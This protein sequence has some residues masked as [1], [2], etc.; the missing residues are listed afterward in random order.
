[1]PGHVVVAVGREA[2]GDR[3]PEPRWRE[4]DHVVAPERGGERFPDGGGLG[5]AVDEDDGHATSSSSRVRSGPY[6]GAGGITAASS[7]TLSNTPGRDSTSAGSARHPKISLYQRNASSS[8]A[9]AAARAAP[10]A[11]SG[12]ATNGTPSIAAR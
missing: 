12:G 3:G 8:V 2:V 4:G 9:T 6:A 10:M 1:E 7:R 5:V 11:T